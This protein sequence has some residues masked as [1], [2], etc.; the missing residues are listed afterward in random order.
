MGVVDKNRQREIGDHRLEPAAERA[1]VGH[2]PG[3]G[4]GVDAAGMGHRS[5]GQSVSQ[6]VDSHQRQRDANRVIGQTEFE[7]RTLESRVQIPGAD[8]P[9]IEP[10][11]KIAAEGFVEEPRPPRIIH[12]QHPPS[13]D[14]EMMVEKPPFG[15]EVALHVEVIVEVIASEIGPDRDLELESG[16]SILH[17]RVRRHFHGDGAGAAFDRSAQDERQIG[18]L[19]SRAIALGDLLITELRPERPDDGGGQT[20]GLEELP[21]ERRGRALAVGSGDADET[22]IAPGITGEGPGHDRH[23]PARTRRT[24]PRQIET[25]LRIGIAQ[26]GAGAGRDGGIEKVET[27]TIETGQR[28]EEIAGAHPTRIVSDADDL[29]SAITFEVGIGATGEEV[30]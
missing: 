12:R 14:R 27:V 18:A 10:P 24:N 6:V 11:G 21:D 26:D 15:R 9:P 28:G 29:G 1:R 23:V 8:I 4:G 22:K 16:D 30:V 17:Q 3:D 7:D 2:P 20:T 19:G 13:A 5:G 25:R